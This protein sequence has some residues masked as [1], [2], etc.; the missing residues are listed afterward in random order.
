[1]YYNVL[2]SEEIYMKNDSEIRQTIRENLINLRKEN[3]LSQTDVA[4]II[5]K[6]KNAVGSWEQGYSLP[7]IETLYRLTKY[8]GKTLNYIYGIEE[9]DKNSEK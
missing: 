7:D 3:N 9:S 6:S 1:M 8:Y 4:K 2:E 5:G